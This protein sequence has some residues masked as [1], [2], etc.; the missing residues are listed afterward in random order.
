MPKR[1]DLEVNETKAGDLITRVA[2]I[3]DSGDGGVSEVSLKVTKDDDMSALLKSKDATIHALKMQIAAEAMKRKALEEQIAALEI[4]L[5]A[6]IS[7][8]KAAKAVLS[9][10]GP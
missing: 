9:S 1:K 7:L 8:M 10:E 6:K 5:A 4:E 2:E 3:S